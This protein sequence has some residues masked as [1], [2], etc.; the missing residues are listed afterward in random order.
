MDARNA[1]IEWDDINYKKVLF[2]YFIFKVS[3]SDPNDLRHL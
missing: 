3:N 2:Y 1:G